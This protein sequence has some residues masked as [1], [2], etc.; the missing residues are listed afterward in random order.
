LVR[1]SIIYNKG[2][3]FDYQEPQFIYAFIFHNRYTCIQ[4]LLIHVHEFF[5][6]ENPA[7]SLRKFSTCYL[8]LP[9][10]HAP[11]GIW[12]G[13]YKSQINSNFGFS[14]LLN[15]HNQI[16]KFHYPIRILTLYPFMTLYVLRVWANR[17]QNEIRVS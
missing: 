17:L 2:S 15:I 5:F 1:Y 6:I 9:T 11:V 13:N 4:I 16:P 8:F 7:I 12:L 10:N 14:C 3:R